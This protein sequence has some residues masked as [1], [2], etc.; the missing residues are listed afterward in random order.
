ME[1]VEDKR[2]LGTGLEVRLSWGW[3]QAGDVFR[4]RKG[5]GQGKAWSW[6]WGGLG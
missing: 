4:I 1:R 3:S 2:K 5:L 6:G